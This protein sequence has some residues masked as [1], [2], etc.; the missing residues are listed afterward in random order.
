MALRHPSY[1]TP[2]A[3]ASLKSTHFSIAVPPTS[4]ILDSLPPTITSLEFD[5]SHLLESFQDPT[6]I[7]DTAWEDIQSLSPT[8]PSCPKSAFAGPL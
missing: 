6:I 5:L 2:R 8:S 1:P 4:A 7:V 3:F